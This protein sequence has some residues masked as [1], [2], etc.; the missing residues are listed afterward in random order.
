MNSWEPSEYTRILLPWVLTAMRCGESHWLSQVLHI[1]KRIE[2]LKDHKV[3][4]TA[5]G[6]RV[7]AMKIYRK[8]RKA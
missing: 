8:L 7:G 6:A 3:Y 2:P 1:R 5:K 4:K